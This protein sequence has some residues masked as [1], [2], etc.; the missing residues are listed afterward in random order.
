MH[1]AVA[2]AQGDVNGVT[3]KGD[4]ADSNIVTRLALA[5]SIQNEFFFGILLP[6]QLPC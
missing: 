3:R 5:A 2:A 4:G 1:A 6:G